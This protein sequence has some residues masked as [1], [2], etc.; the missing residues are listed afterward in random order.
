MST[1]NY[2]QWC[3]ASDFPLRIMSLGRDL[4]LTP[5]LHAIRARMNS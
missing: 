4:S 3:G 1:T 5:T 2:N